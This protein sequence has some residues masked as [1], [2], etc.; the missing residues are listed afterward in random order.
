MNISI[1]TSIVVFRTI[2]DELM[3]SPLGK[4][5]S[6]ASIVKMDG[7][8]PICSIAQTSNFPFTPLNCSK[9]LYASFD[10]VCTFFADFC[11][12]FRFQ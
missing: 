11:F 2:A 6:Q 10:I 1:I 5:Y 4:T 9:G 12:D 3:L 7:L 8:Y